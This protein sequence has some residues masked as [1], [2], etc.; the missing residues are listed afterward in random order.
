MSVTPA[1]KNPLAPSHAGAPLPTALP[2]YPYPPR[3]DVDTDGTRQSQTVVVGV[4]IAGHHQGYHPSV[5]GGEGHRVLYQQ[6]HFAATTTISSG[7][8]GGYATQDPF[9]QGPTYIVQ[10]VGSPNVMVVRG[11]SAASL[12]GA[13]RRAMLRDDAAV[14]SSTSDFDVGIFDCFGREP[15]AM[16]RTGGTGRCTTIFNA[17]FCPY[18][19]AARQINH[20][21][22]DDDASTSQASNPLHWTCAVA[23]AVDIAMS[24]MAVLYPLGYISFRVGSVPCFAWQN[25]STRRAIRRR[26]GLFPS[27]AQDVL[28][29]L[30]CPTCAV[31]Q[32]Q[33]FMARHGWYSG[34]FCDNTPTQK[35][36]LAADL[37][38]P[39]LMM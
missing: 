10:E 14:G 34:A 27:C 3:S 8:P 33:R 30:F 31:A 26:F 35:R 25:F 19:T 11:S 6:Q 37:Q 24:V 17:L 7:P 13:P 21:A 32:Q 12:F 16:D 29:S 5:G 22:S 4:P 1:A 9:R 18:C 20:I 39:M 2:L 38:Q 36:R 28:T 15:T 23:I